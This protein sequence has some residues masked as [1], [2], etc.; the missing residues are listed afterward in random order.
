[1][2]RRWV[3]TAVGIV[4]AALGLLW[5]LQGADVFGGSGGMNGQHIWIV[6]GAIVGLIG[7]GVIASLDSRL[8]RH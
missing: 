6:I 4:L 5:I 3:R 8:G 7:L 1:M 2:T